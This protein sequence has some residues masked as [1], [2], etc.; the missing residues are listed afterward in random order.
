MLQVPPAIRIYT[1]LGPKVTRS[2]T[3]R[4]KTWV[5][6]RPCRNYH[7]CLQ[8][9]LESLE[10]FM[11]NGIDMF[12]T[13]GTQTLRV[14]DV[15]AIA[16]FMGD[17]KSGDT[18]CCRTPHYKQARTC[19]GCYTPFLELSIPRENTHCQWVFQAEQRNLTKN[20]QE[21]GKEND[22]KLRARLKRIST[23]HCDSIMFDLN[24]GSHPGGQ[25]FACTVDLM[26]AF[27]AG[28]VVHVI[29][30]F[31]AGLSTRTKGQVDDLVDKI[32]GEHHYSETDTYPRTNFSKGCTNLKLLSAFDCYLHLSG[33]DF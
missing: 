14:H 25:F 5:T 31:V 9:I 16:I 20:C 21:P 19:R 2:K 4:Q 6:S 8:P 24:Y 27:E 30:A 1:R 23:I 32:F 7:A 12:V 26:H 29:K 33:R 18:L 15:V 3:S 28:V 13:I 11:K 17:G 22:E 10:R